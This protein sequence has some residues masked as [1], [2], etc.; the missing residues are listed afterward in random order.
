MEKGSIA[1]WRASFPRAR[2]AN[3][4]LRV[5]WARGRATPVVDADFVHLQGLRALVVRGCTSV[6]DAFAHLR[7]VRRLDMS[8]C[9][10]AGITC[11]AFAHLHGIRVLDMLGCNQACVAEAQRLL[12]PAPL[13]YWQ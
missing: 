4:S 1:A 11:A 10:Q 2:A 9:T 3:V 5:P 12:Q 7:G 6:T 8:N 13:C